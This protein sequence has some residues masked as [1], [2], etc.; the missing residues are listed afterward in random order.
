MEV[1]S[2]F[3]IS[4]HTFTV[5]LL[6]Y[7]NMGKLNRSVLS[8]IKSLLIKAITVNTVMS[9]RFRLFVRSSVPWVSIVNCNPIVHHQLLYSAHQHA[10]EG[11]RRKKQCTTFLSQSLH[12]ILPSSVRSFSSFTDRS[13]H[14]QQSITCATI[15]I[16]YGRP[17]SQI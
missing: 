17:S 1:R 7:S 6:N 9:N 8:Q 15:S 2:A 4:L 3:K 12:F 11:G 13:I 5:Q 14:K 10:E 16:P